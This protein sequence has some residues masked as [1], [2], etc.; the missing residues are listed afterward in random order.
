MAFTV[1]LH[2]PSSTEESINLILGLETK[3]KY[4]PGYCDTQGC[5]DLKLYCVLFVVVTF[6]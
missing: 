2:L 4:K 1:L 6:S 5:N 3:F